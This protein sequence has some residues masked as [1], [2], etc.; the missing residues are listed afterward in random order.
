ML[1]PPAIGTLGGG[2]QWSGQRPDAEAGPSSAF[3]VESQ[4]TTARSSS[5]S[6]PTD[7]WHWSCDLP[8]M[9]KSYHL[10]MGSLSA[11]FGQESTEMQ[12]WWSAWRTLCIVCMVYFFTNKVWETIR[13]F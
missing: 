12:G 3:E 7:V 5:G 8:V 9:G 6:V 1:A 11:V 2:S 10:S 4:L 13:Q